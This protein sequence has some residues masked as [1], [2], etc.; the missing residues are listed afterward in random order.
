M[1]VEENNVFVP[2]PTNVGGIRT[3]NLFVKNAT[4][5]EVRNIL[6]STDDED[7]TFN[8]KTIMLLAPNQSEQINI[9]WSPPKERRIALRCTIFAYC[10]VIIKP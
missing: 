6:F 3:W 10:Q 5:D 2:V 8:P 1:T 7:V 4:R 9:T